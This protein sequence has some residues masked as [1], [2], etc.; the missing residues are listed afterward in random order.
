MSLIDE[1]IKKK[2]K[3]LKLAK[4]IGNI[5]KA[6]KIMGYH[7]TTYYNL[8]RIYDAEGEE[9]LRKRAKRASKLPPNIEEE[10]LKISAENP[11]WG[12]VKI[13]AELSSQGIIISERATYNI[14]KKNGINLLSQRLNKNSKENH[15]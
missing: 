2:I 10:V 12:S 4:E 15:S 8:K 5:C 13:Q 6:S 3:F 1:E 7:Y 14:L 9:G 11:K